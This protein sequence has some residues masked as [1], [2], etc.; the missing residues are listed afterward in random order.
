MPS[1]YQP[2][3]G[4]PDLSFAGDVLTIL[5]AAI[6]TGMS[7]TVILHAIKRGDLGS[8]V[9]GGGP[10]TGRS[11]GYRIHKA[12]LQRWFLGEEKEKTDAP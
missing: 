12:E 8:F 4:K 3:T 6:A 1:K 2:A 5:Q 9:P 10:A 7:S 11:R